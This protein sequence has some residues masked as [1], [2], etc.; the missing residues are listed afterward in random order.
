VSLANLRVA[1]LKALSPYAGP[2]ASEMPSGGLS[3]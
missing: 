1:P 2:H 3:A